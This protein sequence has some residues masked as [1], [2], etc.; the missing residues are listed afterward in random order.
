ML[1]RNLGRFGSRLALFIVVSIFAGV[2]V[3]ALF[4]PAAGM[5]AQAAQTVSSGMDTVP[6]GA[7]NPAA[8][9]EVDGLPVH[10]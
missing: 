9:G 3:A 2:L 1:L 10:R 5:M 4:I 8:V 6:R 7:G